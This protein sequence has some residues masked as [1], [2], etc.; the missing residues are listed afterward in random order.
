[1]RKNTATQYVAFQ[2]NS[3]TDGSAITTGTPTVYY[4]I[5][6]G[7]QGTGAGA[8]T[9][10]GNGQ[11]SYAPA[12]AE[13]NGDHVAFTMAL[14]GAISQTVN[15]WPVSFDP[16][17]AADLGVTALTGHTPQ[18]GDNYA[19][20]GAP[21]GASV[22]ADIAA[23]K[24]DTAAILVDTADMQPKLGTPAG[25]DISADIAAIKTDTAAI[26]IDTNELQGD[27]TNGG[28]LDLI[29]DAI[30]DDTGTSGVVL[31]SAERNSLADAILDRDMSTGTDSG[32]TTVRTVRQALR[33]NRNKVGIVAGTMTVYKEDDSTASWTAAVTTTA[34]DPISDIDPA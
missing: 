3:S 28:R 27:W 19:R 21:A 9:H 23:A 31:T 29:I 33:A 15:V 22:S 25:T 34:G 4:T 11:W 30:L 12:Q 13:T 17:D 6:G 2:M 14:S 26:L 20:L 32:S 7:T 18:T 24:V 10:E 16:T 5:D 1:M 8:S